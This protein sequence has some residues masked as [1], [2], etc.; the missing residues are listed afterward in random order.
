MGQGYI[1]ATGADE[2]K[3]LQILNSLYGPGT[4]QFLQRAGLQAGMRVVEIGCG[5]GNMSCWLA[6]QVGANG[7]VIGVDVSPAQVEQ[8][9][10]QA[11]AFGLTNV[12]FAVADAYA[13][14]LPLESFDLVYCRLVLMHLTH[15]LDALKQMLALLQSGG[16]LVCEEMDLSQWFA[17]PDN[18]A[19]RRVQAFNLL[20]SDRRG[21]HFRLG[22]GLYQ[23]FLQLGLSQPQ[24]SFSLPA[25]RQGEE[26]RLMELSFAQ[27]APIL[28]EEGLAT[29]AEIE[30]I[31]LALKQ[32]NEDPTTLQ[33]MPVA[34]QVW[35]I[36]P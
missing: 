10:L 35:A 20:L 14:G 1:L 19:F 16:R 33:G 21:Q 4:E 22:T 2:V 7:S 9:R 25:A 15:P 6:R 31:L 18:D 24:I 12:S 8:A 32:F 28:I 3:R 36:K 11:E 5:T 23:L 17:V 30:A 34:G 13:P 26:K 29:V 27:F